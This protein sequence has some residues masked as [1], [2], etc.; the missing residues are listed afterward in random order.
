MTKSP[1]LIAAA[2]LFACAHAHAQDAAVP[3][4]VPVSPGSIR[5]GDYLRT[6]YGPRVDENV[7]GV[8]WQDQTGGGAAGPLAG[9][10][11]YDDVTF[12]GSCSNSL[13]IAINGIAF[14]FW[15]PA[16]ATPEDDHIYLKISFFPSHDNAAP[17]TATPF[18]GTPVTATLDLG[19]GWSGCPGCGQFYG[20]SVTFDHTFA[21][22]DAT[23]VFN[24]GS[25]DRTCGVLEE[26]YA[27][28]ALTTRRSGWGI[29]RR[30][31][32]TS[33][34]I[35][36]SDYFGWFDGSNPNTGT[37]PNDVTHFSGGTAA[38]SRATYLDLQATGCQ[39]PGWPPILGCLVDGSATVQWSVS[40]PGVSWLSFCLNAD[41]TDGTLRFLDIDTEGTAADLAIAVYD[42]VGQLVGMDRDSG[43]GGNAQLSF[44][45]GRRAAVGDGSQYDG[46]NFFGAAG[47]PAADTYYLAVAPNGT[48]FGPSDWAVTP[49]GNGGIFT[50]TLRTNI[51][52]GA[53]DPSVPPAPATGDDASAAPLQSPGIQFAAHDLAPYEVR[54][55][56]FTTCRPSDDTNPV[57]ITTSGPS[58]LELFDTS[59][60]LTAQASSDTAPPTLTFNSLSPLPAATYYLAMSLP[61]VQLAPAPTTAG[62]WHVRSIN[63]TAAPS[64][65]A[66]I[67]VTNATCP[68]GPC[69]RAD[70][71]ADG[72]TG[73]DLDIES[74][75]ACLSGN[76]CAT[77][78]PN[79]DFNCDGDT[80]TDADIESFFRVLAGGGC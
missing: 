64:M 47:L 36:S 20:N 71:N 68:P 79:A 12:G 67:T 14:G 24:A 52:G 26:I 39:I 6:H 61:A 50:L 46:R 33:F 59:G 49:I 43:S 23:N 65:S 54:W 21:T 38:N 74:F 63:N 72:D 16:S 42:R 28:A 8:G 30:A 73:T 18:S 66:L 32:F 5:G 45:I 31:N 9:A 3:Q 27:D 56:R 62:R 15:E 37:I 70:F 51:I 35:G 41:A 57:T 69:C 77:C 48:I 78:P 7:Y 17:A 44:G 34:L 55:L 22:L 19:T 13:P 1:L 10:T 25:T 11:V 80:G 29:M 75:F 40:S 2:V 4:P 76:C 53:L 58:A 60:N